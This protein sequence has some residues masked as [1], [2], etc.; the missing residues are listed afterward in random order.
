MMG[1]Y[2]VAIPHI[3]AGKLRALAVTSRQ[4]ASILQDVPT[5][6]EA[7]YSSYAVDAWTGFFA[8]AGTPVAV[9]DRFNRAIAAA[10][11]T[12]S[13]QAHLAA[14]GASS[15]AGP[16]GEFAVFVQQEWERYG[17]VVRELELKA[18]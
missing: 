15:A 13:V 9:V 1:G 18:E 8:P 7:G 17:K 5:I 14:T 2:V 3:R 12:P 10:L 6:A 11:A 16:P 4:R